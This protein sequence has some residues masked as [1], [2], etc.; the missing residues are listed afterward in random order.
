[1]SNTKH[2]IT[3]NR[4]RI[5]SKVSNTYTAIDSYGQLLL[6]EIYKPLASLDRIMLLLLFTFPVSQ[7]IYIY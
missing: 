5:M 3:N 1:M 4:A 2:F 7:G 6:Q